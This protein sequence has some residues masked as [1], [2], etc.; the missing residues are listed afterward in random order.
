M[1]DFLE[2]YLDNIAAEATQTVV[3]GGPLAVLA[4]SL[5][6]SVD[7]VARQHQ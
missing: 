6:I 7:T 1:M 4:A 5:V 3:K 2:G